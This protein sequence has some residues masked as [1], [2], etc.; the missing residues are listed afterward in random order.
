VPLPA[1]DMIVV[2]GTL[3]DGIAGEDAFGEYSGT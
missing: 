2:P 3:G 1:A